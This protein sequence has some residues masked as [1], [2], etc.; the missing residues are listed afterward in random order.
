MK[1]NRTLVSVFVTAALSLPFF[2]HAAGAQ[3][4]FPGTTD[5]ARAA[6]GALINQQQPV[7]TVRSYDAATPVI[8]SSTDEARALAGQRQV[9]QDEIAS[10]SDRSYARVAGSTDEARGIW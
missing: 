7:Q 2:A 3:D 4:R 10:P 1:S 8:A 6:A 5:E 9:K